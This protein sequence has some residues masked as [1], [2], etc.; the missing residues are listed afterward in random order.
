M[1]PRPIVVPF[2]VW[3]SC[4]FKGFFS[5]YLWAYTW[6]KTHVNPH[7]E[8]ILKVH[9][10]PWGMF[11]KYI[12]TDWY[13]VVQRY[14]ITWNVIPLHEPRKQHRH[15]RRLL[16]C[17]VYLRWHLLRSESFTWWTVYHARMRR[18]VTMTILRPSWY[19]SNNLYRDAKLS[20]IIAPCTKSSQC[21]HRID[22]W[23]VLWFPAD[24]DGK[25]APV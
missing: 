12:V 7:R 22:A 23:S 5:Y 18:S 11:I 9:G 10:S 4:C 24:T 3:W 8:I 19:P 20:E 21:Y 13:H 14:S 16:E 6:T 17:L 2:D 1:V 25:V 15:R